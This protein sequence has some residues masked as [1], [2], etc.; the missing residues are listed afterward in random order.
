MNTAACIGKPTH[1]RR[2]SP[3][4]AR[5]KTSP[6]WVCQDEHHKEQRDNQ[7]SRLQEDPEW[8]LKYEQLKLPCRE[9][10]STLPTMT[11]SLQEPSA[12]QSRPAELED[13]TSTHANKKR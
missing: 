3:L 11:R 9:H 1:G 7:P 10:V 12:C 5:A 6:R 13:K 2:G 4:K 8:L